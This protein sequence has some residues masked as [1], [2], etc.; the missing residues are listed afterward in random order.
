MGRRIPYRVIGVP[1][2]RV[3]ER[4]PSPDGLAW[5]EVLS[6]THQIRKT[7]YEHAACRRCYECKTKTVLNVLDGRKRS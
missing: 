5:I 4:K 6:C 3:L 2:R 1:F 7:D